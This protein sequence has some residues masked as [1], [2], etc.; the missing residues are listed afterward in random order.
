MAG[1]CEFTIRANQVGVGIG[2]KAKVNLHVSYQTAW[3]MA[4]R[5]RY[6]M[7]Q[8]PMAELMTGVIEMDETY[9]GARKKRGS[10]RGVPARTRT[11]CRSS[12]S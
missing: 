1:G 12:R 6:A 7:M 9:V 4:H 11:R 8:G 2:A 10:R 5:L 3:F